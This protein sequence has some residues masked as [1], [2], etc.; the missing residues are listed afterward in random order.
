MAAPQL[1]APDSP[2]PADGQTATPAPLAADGAVAVSP[3][4]DRRRAVRPTERYSYVQ[5]LY[6]LP[7]LFRPNAFVF[8]ERRRGKHQLRCKL[9]SQMSYILNS[10]KV[11][12]WTT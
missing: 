1:T 12:L 8:S 6:Q 11:M 10:R 4:T 2:P 7:G 5:L 9:S 3:S